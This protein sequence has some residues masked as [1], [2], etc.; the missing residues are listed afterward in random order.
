LD[1]D[2]SVKRATIARDDV[3]DALAILAITSHDLQSLVSHAE[4]ASRARDATTMELTNSE[5]IV[6]VRMSWTEDT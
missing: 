6:V 2:G 1:V 4:N 3:D 5:N